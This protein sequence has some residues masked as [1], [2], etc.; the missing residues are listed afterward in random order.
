MAAH[1]N[2]Q[3]EK[4]NLSKYTSEKIIEIFKNTNSLRKI[5]AEHGVSVSFVSLIKNK[6]RWKHILKDL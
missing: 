3:G 6:K 4:S 2:T 1:E 5:A